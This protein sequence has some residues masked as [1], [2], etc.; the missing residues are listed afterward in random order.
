[1]RRTTESRERTDRVRMR[2]IGIW[3]AVAAALI[4]AIVVAVTSGGSGGLY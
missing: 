1:M 3:L 2:L 4:V